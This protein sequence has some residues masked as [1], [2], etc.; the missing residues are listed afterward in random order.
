MDV[1]RLAGAGG[2]TVKDQYSLD[3]LLWWR[4]YFDLI[5]TRS[6]KPNQSYAM[7]E[8]AVKVSA[9]SADLALDEY[10]ARRGER[11]E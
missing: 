11:K 5:L 8:Y 6:I 7:S 4:Q 3:E 9:L 1:S 2:G 10:L